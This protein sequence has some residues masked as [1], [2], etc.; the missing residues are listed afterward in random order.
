[1]RLYHLR[2]PQPSAT[3][4]RC[5]RHV[6]TLVDALPLSMPRPRPARRVS[7]VHNACPPSS[8]GV[9]PPQPGCCLDD[10][11]PPSSTMLVRSP[12]PARPDSS[13][14]DALFWVGR[15]FECPVH[16]PALASRDT[17]LGLRPDARLACATGLGPPPPTTTSLRPDRRIC[18]RGDAVTTSSSRPWSADRVSALVDAC[19]PSTTRLRPRGRM[20]ALHR[21]DV[22]HGVRARRVS[23]RL[24]LAEGTA[25]SP[26]RVLAGTTRLRCCAHHMSRCVGPAAFASTSWTRLRPA[27]RT[28]THPGP[29]GRDSEASAPLSP[30]HSNSTGKLT[31]D[32]RLS[33]GESLSLA[34]GGSTSRPTSSA[35]IALW[36]AMLTLQ[37]HPATASSLNL[38]EQ[39]DP[40]SGF[41]YDANRWQ[42][43]TYSVRYT[44]SDDDRLQLP[45]S[46]PP[47]RHR[48]RAAVA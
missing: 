8:T 27:R 23:S 10:T 3:R 48:R 45:L 4:L 39:E 33:V 12:L 24:L 1:M 2:M 44:L 38:P 26:T 34:G 30:T 41:P 19:P 7:D 35:P 31:P 13:L 47:H 36:Q 11:T 32:G 28:T 21:D 25:S 16:I 40:E 5:P 29:C 20:S 14:L 22:L 6:S 17:L 9:R 42:S 18:A 15:A 43:S 46:A 37:I